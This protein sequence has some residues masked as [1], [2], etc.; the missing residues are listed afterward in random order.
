MGGL[1]QCMHFAISP[2]FI[3]VCTVGVNGI[4]C[5]CLPGFSS[6]D[7]RNVSEGSEWRIYLTVPS[8][9]SDG[10]GSPKLAIFPNVMGSC[11]G[12]LAFEHLKMWKWYVL[13]TQCLL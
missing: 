11:K 13:L 9:I 8:A 12:Q 7:V 10:M 2:T 6:F 5:V 4:W 1:R 3:A